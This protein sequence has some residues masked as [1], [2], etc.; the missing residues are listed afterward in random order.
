MI[1][2]VAASGQSGETQATLLALPCPTGVRP[3]T[4]VQ[5][6]VRFAGDLHDVAY[7]RDGRYRTF[8]CDISIADVRH[9]LQDGE[10]VVA[11]DLVTITFALVDAPRDTPPRKRMERR[12]LVYGAVSLALHLGIWFAAMRDDTEPLPSVTTESQGRRAR[13]SSSFASSAHTVKWSTKPEPREA[14]I[15]TDVTPAPV[16]A[17]DTEENGGQEHIDPPPSD[18]GS[19]IVDRPAAEHGRMR[20]FD[21]DASPDFDTIKTGT[22]STVSTG[23][24]SGTQYG[25]A[26][27]RTNLVVVSCDSSSCL[28]LGGENAAPIRKAVEEHLTEITA[29]Y[30]NEARAAGKKVEIDLGID[31]TGKVDGLQVGGIGDVGNC[32]AAILNR[33]SFAEQT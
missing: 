29:C 19:I 26:A 1:P 5:V 25:V 15:T 18:R 24:M 20:K 27:R 30:E 12:P 21:P 16:P 28:V 3:N 4:V 17:T 9:Q 7:L 10:L 11:R 8:G 33:T 32:V 2:N 6:V 13:I 14:R 23:R 31:A 22:F